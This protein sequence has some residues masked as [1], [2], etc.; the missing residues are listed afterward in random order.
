MIDCPKCKFRQP[1]DQY[2]ANCGIDMVAYQPQPISNSKNF[3]SSRI[4]P[5]LIIL[6][7][8][9]ISSYFIF[10][11]D[12]PQMWI[13][14]KSYYKRIKDPTKSQSVQMA[15][16]SVP[17]DSETDDEF[18]SHVEPANVEVVAAPTATV[19]QFSAPSEN[20]SSRQTYAAIK[21]SYVEVNREDLAL[22]V[23]ESQRLGLYQNNLDLS[24]G[25]LPN[26][27]AD[28]RF[29]FKDLK[30]ETKKLLLQ[31]TEALLSGKTFD[32]T[33]T[34]IGF[35]ADID[36]KSIENK[37]TSGH[38][39]IKKY[40]RA[41]KIDLPLEFELQQN[42]VFFIIWKTALVGFQNE[43]SLFTIPPFNILLSQEYLNQK[44]EFVILVE[45]VEPK[46]PSPKK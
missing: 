42:S 14:K 28:T 36:I 39:N 41:G 1:K 32:E 18:V 7:A 27:T 22:L 8:A 11:N 38:L 29:K 13:K 17:T 16:A 20:E 31:Q 25:I 15:S 2:C 46:Q 24:A 5:V 33:S 12:G 23:S 4:F 26:Y 43:T 35:Q 44:T 45:S 34:F 10:K 19:S 40:S 3:F 21:L 37:T 30:V 6:I 9:T